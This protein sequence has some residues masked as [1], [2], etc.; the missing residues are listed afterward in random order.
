LKNLHM[1]NMVTLGPYVS[2][3]KRP[4]NVGPTYTCVG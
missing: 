4:R 3:T 2:G 1:F